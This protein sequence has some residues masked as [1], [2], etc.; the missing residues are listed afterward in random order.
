MCG[1]IGDMLQKN[2]TEIVAGNQGAVMEGGC[3]WRVIGD[4]LLLPRLYLIISKFCR[5]HVHIKRGVSALSLTHSHTHSLSLSLSLSLSHSL[6][7]SLALS[8]TLSLSF[9][10]SPSLS[11]SLTHTETDRHKNLREQRQCEQA[12]HEHTLTP[13][14]Q[15]LFHQKKGDCVCEYHQAM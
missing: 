3:T 6:T 13:H 1:S 2:K 14:I 9:S 11:L 12:E 8:L 7:L 15:V 4:M 5:K 10:L